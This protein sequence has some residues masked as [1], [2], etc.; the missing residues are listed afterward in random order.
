[1]TIKVHQ[2][3]LKN[4]KQVTYMSL[5]KFHKPTIHLHLIPLEKYL[6]TKVITH[7]QKPMIIRVHQ[8]TLKQPN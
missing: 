5:E 2:V 8:L 7:I 4:I 6:I 3:I 1:M